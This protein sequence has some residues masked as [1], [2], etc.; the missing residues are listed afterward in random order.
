MTSTAAPPDATQPEAAAEADLPRGAR[1]LRPMVDFVA[2]INWSV[3]RK[4]MVGF[5][6]GA[7]LLLAMGLLSL[8]VIARMDDRVDAIT[9]A[10]AKAHYAQQMLYE[11]TAQSHYRAMS[12]LQHDNDPAGAVVQVGKIADAKAEFRDDLDR[13]DRALGPDEKGIV[14]RL[15]ATDAAFDQASSEV[16]RLYQSDTPSGLERAE[17]LHM[18][19]EHP[20]SHA[21]EDQLNPFIDSANAEVSAAQQQFRASRDLLTA[22]VVVFCAVSVLVALWLGL[23]L[24]WAFVIPVRRVEKALGALSAGEFPSDVQ[25]RSRDEFGH[26]AKDLNTTSRR[27]RTMF[28]DQA[29]LAQELRR[30]NVSLIK[31]N[32]AKSRFLA[33]VSHELRTPLNAILGFTE[34]LLSGVDGP[35]NEEQRTSLE[36]VRRGGKDLLDLINEILDLSKIEAGKLTITPESFDPRQL[37]EAVVAQHRSLAVQKG[38]RLS[39][40]ECGAPPVVYQDRQRIRQILVNLLGNAVKF[41]AEGDV[42]VRVSG[43]EHVL[44]VTV[45]DTGRGIPVEEQK[46]I[47][48]EFNRGRGGE[49]G[50]GLGLS[51]SLRLAHALGGELTLQSAEGRGS[52]FELRLPVDY[53]TA[54]AIRA[55]ASEPPAASPDTAA[56]VATAA[57]PPSVE[58]AL[59]QKQS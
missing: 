12:F 47:F 13:L 18:S 58:A 25:V 29:L 2:G 26:L 43:D 11:V 23:V 21:L 41:T 10:Q 36:W 9:R 46:A 3:R 49:P 53:R 33:N 7:A 38:I 6:S 55:E 45:E 54:Q 19:Q 5:L 35:L 32:E 52:T 17:A 37:V 28:A 31:A 56:L 48:E 50:T 1:W 22:L 24:S 15:R 8:V 30:T 4:L 14:D 59:E 34:A 51:I 44:S 20:I 27:L 42:D 16:L 39:S 40:G 57:P